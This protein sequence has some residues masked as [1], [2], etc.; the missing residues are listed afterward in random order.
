MSNKNTVELSKEDIAELI[1]GEEVYLN[2][3]DED[4]RAFTIT[5]RLKQE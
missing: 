2:A 4:G 1:N 5:I 3:N